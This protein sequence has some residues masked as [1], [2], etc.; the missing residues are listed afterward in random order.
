MKRRNFVI[1]AGLLTGASWLSL[2]RPAVAASDDATR[3][4]RLASS[5]AAKRES[6]ARII[7]VHHHLLPPS[8]EASWPNDYA[9]QSLTK[10]SE[11]HSLAMMD[12]RN[13]HT[14]ILS[15]PA[16]G[17]WRGE[18]RAATQLARRAN[19]YSAE[20]EQRH[21]GRYGSFASVP[22]PATGQACAEAV[23]ALDTLKADGVMLLAS[24]D[25][26]FLGDP[27]F[28]ELMAELDS[29][30]ATVFVQPNLQ[31]NNELL[32]LEAPGVMLEFACD[33]SRAAVNLI[34][35]GTM[36][37]YP[38]IRW[39]LANGGGFLP[40]AAWRIS[41][42]NALPEFQE[43]APLGVMTYL[44][45]FYFDTTLAAGAPTMAVLKELVDPSQVLFGSGF[46]AVPE[47]VMQQEVEALATS[48]IWSKAEY[49]AITRGNSLRLFSRHALSGEAV[50]AAPVYE[51]E[52]TLQWL[53]RTATKPL[54]AAAQRLK[55]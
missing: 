44:R 40:Y 41:L 15:L 22:L 50:V 45:R 38:R 48:S 8:L 25:G 20:L 43:K 36:E 31:P 28:D 33:V 23:Y 1:G 13:I 14:A 39:I 46:L 53:A 24:N 6:A 52:S 27:Q 16:P 54:S 12:Q 9:G 35:S 4:I 17:V 34:L 2:G 37:R 7:D 51:P 11:A 5:V 3:E 10:W 49:S 47:D 18:S 42:A 55:D 30:Q 19:E 29:R 21:P 26:K 32:A